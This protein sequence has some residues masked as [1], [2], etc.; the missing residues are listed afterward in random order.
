MEADDLVTSVKEARRSELDRLGSDRR[1]LALTGADLTEDRV[2]AAATRGERAARET[3]EVWAKG[4]SDKDLASAYREI[5]E[6]EAEHAERLQAERDENGVSDASADG[7][8][9]FLR[10]LE[11]PAAQVGAG[12][13]G[14]PLV[15]SQTQLQFVNFFLNEA[16]TRRADLFRSLR[17]DTQEQLEIGRELLPS[18]CST[19]SDWQRAEEAALEAID[20]VYAEYA[21]EL[22]E[23][24]INP[25]SIC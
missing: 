3:F 7:L 20:I 14:R 21:E 6:T 1:L 18:V 17:T 11:H 5:A 15:G 9:Q 23:L 25:K 4:A 19:S 13:I 12:L 10:E 8:H 2:L 24:G 22:N 16:D